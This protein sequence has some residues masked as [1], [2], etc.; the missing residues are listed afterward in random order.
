MKTSQDR[1]AWVTFVALVQL[2]AVLAIVAGL[3]C[4]A[5]TISGGTLATILT[6][7]VGVSRVPVA[8][9]GRRARVNDD[10]DDGDGDGPPKA[11]PSAPAPKTGIVLTSTLLTIAVGLA[12]WVGV[13]RDLWRRGTS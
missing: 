13:G 4:W 12:A 1:P 11:P 5:G 8:I 3:A 9:R 2:E 6:T 7:I 10:D